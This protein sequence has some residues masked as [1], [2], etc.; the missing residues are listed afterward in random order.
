M[1]NPTSRIDDEEMLT[2][3]PPNNLIATNLD[4]LKKNQKLSA[5]PQLLINE[6]SADLWFKKDDTFEMP[7]AVVNLLIYT[8]DI[9]ST[10]DVN[11]RVFALVWSEVVD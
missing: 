4:V 3:P 9:K 6:P 1:L 2:L 5:K 11:A 8:N 10:T 7:K